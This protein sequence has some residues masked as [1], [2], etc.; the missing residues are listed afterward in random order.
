[1][2][3]REEL[4]DPKSCLN[5]AADDEMLFVILGRD[6]AA[7]AAVRAWV[8]ERIRIGKNK[9]GDPKILEALAWLGRVTWEQA[10]KKEQDFG[11]D[12]LRQTASMLKTYAE[13]CFPANEKG[14]VDFARA[15]CESAAETIDRHL[16]LF[17]GIAATKELDK[18]SD[19]V[20]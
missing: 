17:T 8:N 19:P 3:K 11:P 14:Q 18:T 13:D 16:D 2:L 10:A 15:M 20:V 5:K 4:T 9:K 7:C 6:P 1:M 12:E